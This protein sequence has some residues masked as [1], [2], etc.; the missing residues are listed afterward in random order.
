M[1]GGGIEPPVPTG[2]LGL[3]TFH[4]PS[5]LGL[6]SAG[7]QNKGKLTVSWPR[8]RW[9]PGAW[10]L[11]QQ[12]DPCTVGPRLP[13]G[14]APGL[15]TWVPAS[16]DHREPRSLGL[17]PTLKALLSLGQLRLE[18]PSPAIRGALY[19]G[20]L[21]VHTRVISNTTVLAIAWWGSQGPRADLSCSA[22]RHLSSPHCSRAGCTLTSLEQ[23]GRFKIITSRQA[24]PSPRPAF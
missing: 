7:P 18:L 14:G 17:D 23:L 15:E 9:V 19:K 20:P 24:G 11:C 5:V 2:V 8:G 10:L 4:L 12:G 22:G 3:R 1:A 21:A 16:Q 13:E 6:S